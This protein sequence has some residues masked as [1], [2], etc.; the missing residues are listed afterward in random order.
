[1]ARGRALLFSLQREKLRAE[2]T[3]RFVVAD[4]R[5]VQYAVDSIFL[6]RS[7]VAS[8]IVVVKQVIES[9]I[10]LFWQFL[11]EKDNRQRHE[12]LGFDR[13]LLQTLKTS[14]KVHNHYFLKAYLN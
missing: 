7:A 10:I 5:A 1:M 11:R 6:H 4:R 12:L 14:R 8:S 3:A 9:K 2:D 13:P